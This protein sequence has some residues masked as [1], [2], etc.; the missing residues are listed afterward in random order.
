M[1]PGF[2]RLGAMVGIGKK[3]IGPYDVFENPDQPAQS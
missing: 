1:K 3:G 2:W